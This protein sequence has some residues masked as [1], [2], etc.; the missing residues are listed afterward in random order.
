MK[1]YSNGRVNV[2]DSKAEVKAA[3]TEINC[4]LTDIVRDGCEGEG[5]VEVAY[6]DGKAITFDKYI[7]TVT[8]DGRELTEKEARRFKLAMTNVRTLV[9]TEDWG[10]TV[11]GEVMVMDEDG[12]EGADMDGDFGWIEVA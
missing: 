4:E 9:V 8:V 3:I 12:N 10:Y 2:L 11:Y 5:L 6:N 1:E 7:G